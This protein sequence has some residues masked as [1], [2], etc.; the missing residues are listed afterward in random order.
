MLRTMKRGFR[1]IADALI[2]TGREIHFILGFVK[3]KNLD[4][5]IPFSTFSQISYS[6]V[7]P[8]VIRGMEPEETQNQYFQ[9]IALKDLHLR[10]FTKQSILDSRSGSYK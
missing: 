2:K 6:F 5:I 1:I 4:K 8:N 10:T 3:E 9:N 7:K